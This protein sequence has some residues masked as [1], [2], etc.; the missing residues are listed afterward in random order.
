MNPLFTL[1]IYQKKKIYLT[2]I[3][4]GVRSTR[5]KMNIPPVLL[6]QLNITIA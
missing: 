2:Y 1:Y 3:Y 6:D 4:I 5:G